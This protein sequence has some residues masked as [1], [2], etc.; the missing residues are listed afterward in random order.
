MFLLV[1]SRIGEISANSSCSPSSRNHWNDW[2][3]I[4]MRFGIGWISLM[5]AKPWRSSPELT[6]RENAG[7]RVMRC[8]SADARWR[9]G[10]E[11]CRSAAH[12]AQ[13]KIPYPGGGLLGRERGS[14][15]LASLSPVVAHG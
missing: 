5:R 9:V 4:V 14:A 2:R 7:A 1:K 6:A 13:H 12:G 8:T 11:Q 3:W 15:L 10:E